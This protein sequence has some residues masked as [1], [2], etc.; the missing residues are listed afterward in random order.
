MPLDLT[1]VF[2]TQTGRP[3]ALETGL[4]A[5]QRKARMSEAEFSLDQDVS[6]IG[7]LDDE[8]EGP[9]IA[10]R[11]SSLNLDPSSINLDE[12]STA[13]V[14]LGDGSAG[15]KRKSSSADEG[16]EEEEK[17]KKK[18]RKARK[19]KV[20]VDQGS[21][22]LSSAHIRNM[23]EDTS[24]I[25][26][27]PPPIGEEE[28][29][30]NA[31]DRPELYGLINYGA[32]PLLMNYLS[33][34]QLFARPAFADDGQC[35]PELLQIWKD[36]ARLRDFAPERSADG[37]V[38]V[39]RQQE[40]AD[41]DEEEEETEAKESARD[42]EPPKLDEVD[43]EEDDD[44][45]PL[46]DD[47]DEA[48]A[49]PDDEEDAPPLPDDDEEEE[50]QAESPR[51]SSLSLGLENSFGDDEWGNAGAEGD[52]RQAAG[53]E[54]VSSNSK[55]HK[56]TIKV[57]SLLKARLGDAEGM[58]PHLSYNGLTEGCNRRTAVNVYFELLQLKTWDFIELNQDEPY[59]D[60][61]V[62]PGPKFDD[63]VPK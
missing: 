33:Y 15:S 42:E 56:H 49:F 54:L 57:F 24:D 40:A 2:C 22:E 29:P 7:H 53:D 9:G 39:P 63:E 26:N 60:I 28:Q 46:P 1:S 47:D 25:V 3:S 27:V 48:P 13:A 62:S 41:T 31:T 20:I 59:G 6:G 34:E 12:G 5:A 19:R 4:T 51:K 10:G 45:P 58:E 11:A 16:E 36:V 52:D 61:I 32:N 14:S 17:P 8:D 23:L 21:I 30:R 38:E 50:V 44:A 37:S 35:S 55:W 18:R 43:D